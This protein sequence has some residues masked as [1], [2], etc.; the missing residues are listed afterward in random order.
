MSLPLPVFS[1]PGGSGGQTQAAPPG[2]TFLWPVLD[3]QPRR[4]ATTDGQVLLAD[5]ELADSLS[6]SGRLFGLVNSVSVAA[7][8]NSGLLGSMC[9]AVDPDLLQTVD[10]MTRGYKVRTAS[11]ARSPARAR[12]RPRSG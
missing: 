6:V 5:D 10:A 2:L 9:F 4:L 1:V 11:A 8:A 3:T 7:A 12:P